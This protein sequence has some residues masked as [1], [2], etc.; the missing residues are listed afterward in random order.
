MLFD[1]IVDDQIISNQ[2]LKIKVKQKQVVRQE[3]RAIG[4]ILKFTSN[5]R[6]EVVVVMAI[7]RFPL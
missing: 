3:L 1:I 6:D 4:T 5:Y 2:D 7:P